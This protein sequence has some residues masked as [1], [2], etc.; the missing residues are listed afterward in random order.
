MAEVAAAS[1]AAAFAAILEP[2]VLASR[3]A[4]RFSE[5][6]AREWTAMWVAEAE[7]RV[8]GFAEMRGRHIDML[9]VD[10]AAQRQGAGRALLAALEAAGAA[11]LECFRDNAGARAFYE[12]AGWRLARGY[13]RE[14]EG[15]R[16]DFVWYE[17]P[18]RG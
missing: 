8:L 18:A 10:P 17:K 13:A 7:G 14:L 1:Y 9:F 12:H 5:R 11:T 6:F 4:A 16:R 15:R 2:E 3:T